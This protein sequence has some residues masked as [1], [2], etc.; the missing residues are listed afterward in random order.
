MAEA[1]PR[2]LISNDDGVSAPGLRA[3]VEALNSHRFCQIYICGPFG[4]RS[5]QS[6]SITSK[7]DSK[8]ATTSGY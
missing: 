8:L 2:I 7:Y 1:L 3:L 5:A 4:E 6:H